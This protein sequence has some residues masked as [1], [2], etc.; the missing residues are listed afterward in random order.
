VKVCFGGRKNHEREHARGCGRDRERDAPDDCDRQNGE[1]VESAEAENRHPL[2][3][4]RDRRGH[5]SDDAGA[6]EYAHD[7]LAPGR[8][9]EPTPMHVHAARL[10]DAVTALARRSRRDLVIRSR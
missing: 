2:V 9:V 5:E 1:D 6:R 3:D 8:A 4:Y 7:Y 10:D